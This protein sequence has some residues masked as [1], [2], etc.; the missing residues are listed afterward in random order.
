MLVTG[1]ESLWSQV[2]CCLPSWT[3]QSKC[4]FPFTNT[5][6]SS[7][8]TPT[9]PDG[10]FFNNWTKWTNIVTSPQ[11]STKWLNTIHDRQ[12]EQISLK[13]YRQLWFQLV[14]HDA[15]ICCNLQS[16]S[17]AAEE[18]LIVVPKSQRK[19]FLTIVHDDSDEHQS[20]DCTL[21]RLSEMA[22]WM[23]MGKDVTHCCTHSFTC[24]VFNDPE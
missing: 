3:I 4:R 13:H 20:I 8:F 16:P 12:L 22:Y 18:L 11:P 2:W 5:C 15:I 1:I 7:D 21:A 6:I 17:M 9:N 24:Q 19:I 14:L 23:G 10:W